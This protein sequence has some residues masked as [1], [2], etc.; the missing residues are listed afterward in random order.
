M[1][2]QWFI[3]FIIMMNAQ[4]MFKIQTNELFLIVNEWFS[5]FILLMATW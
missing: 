5:Y 3:N 1:V 4:C 2:N